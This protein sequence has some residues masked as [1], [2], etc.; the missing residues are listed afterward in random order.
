M[1]F[2]GKEVKRMSS[3][4]RHTLFW[5]PRILSILFAVFL[6]IFALDVFDETKG[7]W[8]TTAALLIHLIPS[9]IVLAVLLIA[10]RW[11]WVGAALYTLAAARYAAFALPRHPDWFIFIGSP[12]LLMAALF[13]LNW[14][15]RADMRRAT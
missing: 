15:K 12:L 5:L 2:A 13:L 7:F 10:W 3:I 11:E 4:S 1:R 6:S 14:V 9:F 8:P